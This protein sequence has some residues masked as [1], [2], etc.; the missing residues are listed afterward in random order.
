MDSSTTYDD[1]D[2]LQYQGVWELVDP[3]PRK[4]TGREDGK[5]GRHIIDPAAFGR[6]LKQIEEHRQRAEEGIGLSQWLDE[7]QQQY[8]RKRAQEKQGQ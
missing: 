4:V 6:L 8:D 2:D 5:S 1:E 7:K 3:Q